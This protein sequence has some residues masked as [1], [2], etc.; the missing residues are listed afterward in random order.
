MVL[1]LI[2][3]SYT[4]LNVIS[5]CPSSIIGR[6]LPRWWVRGEGVGVFLQNPGYWRKGSTVHLNVE[7]NSIFIFPFSGEADVG[8]NSNVISVSSNI[9]YVYP[10]RTKSQPVPAGAA[11]Q[12]WHVWG[13]GRLRSRTNIVINE[14]SDTWL[15]QSKVTSTSV[16]QKSVVEPG[17]S[18]SPP[19]WWNVGQL[20]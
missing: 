8:S 3:F 20:L 18:F 6:G 14:L 13:K 16:G 2:Y 7:Y 9:Y 5:V 19:K 10:H 4:S 11:W 1:I 15:C 12:N 17:S